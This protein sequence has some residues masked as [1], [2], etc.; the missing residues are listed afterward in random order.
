M[1]KD[2]NVFDWNRLVLGTPPDTYYFEILVRV[3]FIFI[4]LVAV[5]R[6]IG[7]RGQRSLTPMQQV[8]LIALGSVT[9]D[10]TFYPEV[11]LLY[12][13]VVL[14][15]VT[16]MLYLLNHIK[17]KSEFVDRY[18]HSRP[19]I[20]VESGEICDG[21]EKEEQLTRREVYTLLR[22][23]GVRFLEEVEYAILESDGSVSVFKQEIDPQK[24]TTSLI[25]SA[26]ERDA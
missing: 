12:V 21:A 11:P 19:L 15:T 5:L 25:D 3:V 23:S 7:K 14:F 18:L 6:L 1:D 26:K 10:A 8:L 16:A 2:L 22:A 4:I 24:K 20:I 13:A 9:G 17:R